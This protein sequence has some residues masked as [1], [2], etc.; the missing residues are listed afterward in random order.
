[1]TPRERVRLNRNVSILV[2]VFILV[3]LLAMEVASRLGPLPKPP[4]VA[5][6]APTARL[7]P[8]MAMP[9]NPAVPPIGV[10]TYGTSPATT[11][12]LD[13]RLP[14]A[15]ERSWIITVSE[16]RALAEKARRYDALRALEDAYAAGLLREGLFPVT[17][18]ET[19]P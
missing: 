4:A 10:S 9:P 17:T 3:G 6:P 19:R 1:M 18:H 5:Q 16:Y 15:S 2:A 7:S 11:P 13:L 12:L 14:T 8:E